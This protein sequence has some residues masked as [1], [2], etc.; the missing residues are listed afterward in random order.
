[1]LSKIDNTTYARDFSEFDWDGLA[2]AESF[3]DGSCPLIRDLGNEAFLVGDKYGVSLHIPDPE[4][5]YEDYLELY[6]A[7][8][9][10]RGNTLPENLL[11]RELV[12]AIMNGMPTDITVQSAKKD[13]GFISD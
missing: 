1:M 13:F 5:D 4:T 12:R 7:I 3:D 11:K 2:G 8:K 9:D 10:E 6:L